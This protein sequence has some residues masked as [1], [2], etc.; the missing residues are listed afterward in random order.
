MDDWSD[1]MIPCIRD[2]GNHVKVSA[3]VVGWYLR[4]AECQMSE[5]EEKN[6]VVS[7]ENGILIFL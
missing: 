4:E 1:M 7:R 3:S 6:A 5:G 2:K